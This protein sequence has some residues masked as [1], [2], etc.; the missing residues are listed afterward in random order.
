MNNQNPGNLNSSGPQF[1]LDNKKWINKYGSSIILPIIALL[2]L[3]GG[4]YLYANQKGQEVILTLDEE[5]NQEEEIVDITDIEG[6]IGIT[7]DDNQNDEAVIQEIIPESRKEGKMII[8]KAN[9]GEG[10]TH[11][12]RRALKNYLEDNPQELTNEHKVYIE[13]Y[14]KDKTGLNPLEIGE[15]VSFSE[16]LVKEAIDASLQLTP[17]QLKN[18]EQ[19]SALVAW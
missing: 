16:D 17:D 14:L 5:V 8:E 6:L 19:Y 4:I 11:L 9:P 12:A 7:E 3:A 15:E 10:V 13:D 18:L 2:I 1:G